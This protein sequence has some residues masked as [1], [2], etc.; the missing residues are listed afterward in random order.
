MTLAVISHTTLKCILSLHVHR[1]IELFN[2]GI[3]L[4]SFHFF[5][6]VFEYILVECWRTIPCAAS[7][8]PGGF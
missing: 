4:F 1:I 6:V 3:I 2:I 8:S 7:G 5:V